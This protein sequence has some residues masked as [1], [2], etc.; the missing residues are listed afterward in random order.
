M[1]WLRRARWIYFSQPRLSLSFSTEKMMVCVRLRQQLLYLSQCVWVSARVWTQIV[2]H[3][4]SPLWW[5]PLMLTPFRITE[6][7]KWIPCLVWTGS[8]CWDS[9]KDWHV[10]DLYD[11][12]A[13]ITV[14]LWSHVCP[15]QP[16][17]LFYIKQNSPLNFKNFAVCVTD[18]RRNCWLPG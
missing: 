1:H 18:C 17:L 9:V 16:T 15:F 5:I 8:I 7:D 6:S 4:F 11:L 12:W 2:R 3:C 13:M 10:N 14:Q